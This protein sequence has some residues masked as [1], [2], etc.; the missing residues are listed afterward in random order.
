MLRTYRLLPGLET[1]KSFDS[2]CNMEHELTSLISMFR[3]SDLNSISLPDLMMWTIRRDLDTLLGV[4]GNPD[5]FHWDTIQINLYGLDMALAL[6][7]SRMEPS[8]FVRFFVLCVRLNIDWSFTQPNGMNLLHLIIEGASGGQ[9]GLGDFC[10]NMLIINGV[11][12]C[13]VCDGYLTPTL[14]AFSVDSLDPWFTVLRQ[15]RISVE[16]VAAHALGLLTESN[17]RNIIFRMDHE[18]GRHIDR[19]PVL[20]RYARPSD[21]RSIADNTK[22]LRADLIEAFERQGC[23]LSES[24]DIGNMVTYKA[25]S[26]VDFTPSTVFD[27]ERAKQ[28]LRRRTGARKH[29]PQW[30]ISIPWALEGAMEASRSE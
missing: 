29:P 26:S 30:H 5:N 13:A 15:T 6:D 9:I 22:Q 16:T 19:H 8:L 12:P 24:G 28:D 1:S 7:F 10:L 20:C 2:S 3:G 25:S 11:D 17:M 21:W 14:S 18:P 23:Y 4:V 27:P